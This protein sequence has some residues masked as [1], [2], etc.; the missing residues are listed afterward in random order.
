MA[1]GSSGSRQAR[2]GCT[3]AI[4]SLALLLTSVAVPAAPAPAP[5]GAVPHV[6]AAPQTLA[7]LLMPY[8]PYLFD[9]AVLSGRNFAEVTYASRRYDPVTRDFVATGVAIHRDAFSATIARIRIGGGVQRL[10]GVAVDTRAL[11]LDPAVRQTLQKLGRETVT[12]DVSLSS[13]GGNAAAADYRLD[14]GLQLDGIA[15]LAVSLDVAGFHILMPLHEADPA[16]GASDE[17]VVAGRLQSGRIAY[18]DKGLLPAV[19][20]VY[21]AQQGLSGTQFAGMASMLATAGIA[22]A[23]GDAAGKVS[24]ALQARAQGWASTLQTF[25]AHPSH[26]EVTLAPPEPVELSWLQGE[27]D[28]EAAIAALNP[29]VGLEAA[30]SVPLVAADSFPAAASGSEAVAAARQLIEGVGVPQDVARGL[31]L[32]L[33]EAAKGD[34]AALR[35]VSDALSRQPA[36]AVADG[37]GQRSYV[38]LLLA[39]AD[40]VA[41]PEDLLSGLRA[42]IGG[43]AAAAAE[44][45]ALDAWMKT[46]AG[47]AHR[48]QEAEA[49][50]ARNWST[51]GK[52]AF[53][54]Y[55]GDA[56]PRN[57]TRAYGWSLI[58]AAGGDAAATALRDDLNQAA[59][60]GRIDLP[61]TRARVIANGLWALILKQDAAVAPAPAD[62]GHAEPQAPT[63]AAP[64]Q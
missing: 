9:L 18:D 17:P 5:A 11:P 59:S 58:A 39:H 27:P 19:F 63:P 52:L 7:D 61:V 29:Q 38:T 49:L 35:L 36:L 43:E 60:D 57:L 14:L 21:G 28:V 30:P 37:A 41:L 50:A 34:N 20:E 24:P 6:D 13:A 53:A 44:D 33:P 55:E 64:A 1:Q 47:Q 2:R 48:R 46:D 26:L 3:C 51:I 40:G 16:G 15:D 62:A 8:A 10:E 54:Y 12:G 23:F 31:E 42:S 32:A 4:A 22:G 45:E 25:I 56:V